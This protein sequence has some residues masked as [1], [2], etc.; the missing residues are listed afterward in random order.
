MC[1]SVEGLVNGLGTRRKSANTRRP[2]PKKPPPINPHTGK[3]DGRCREWRP[4]DPLVIHFIQE[5]QGLKIGVRTVREYSRDIEL[6]GA[7][8]LGRPPFDEEGNPYRGPFGNTFER[9]TVSSVRQFL[10]HLHTLDY[11]AAAT[12]RKMAVLRRF[13]DFVKRNGL[14]EDNPAREIQIIRLPKRQPKAIPVKDVM[15]L[16]GT[17]IPDQPE[18]RWRR[19][20]AMLE[21]LYASGMR[22][23]E[24]VGINVS[25]VEF[26]DRRIRVIGKGNNER[27]VF[28]NKA[29]AEALKAYLRVRPRCK[30]GALFV[31]RQGRRLSYQQVGR[32]F[33]TYVTLSG[34]EGKI[35]PHT[36]RHSIA[37]HLHK[38]GVDLMTIKEFL[39]HASIQTTQIYSQMEAEHV[40]R[41]LEK[42]HP[43][44]RQGDVTSTLRKRLATDE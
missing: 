31:S 34:L 13:F 28:F 8:L 16:I 3:P 18:I 15:K 10:M 12:R 22:R 20:I 26:T 23:A 9:A 30:D 19:D 43:R 14:R 4:A 40:R 7:F 24:L 29:T 11:E 32:I 17:R 35:T 41:S 5:L 36:M 6:F 25:D 1:Y 42:H 38:S 21:L 33:E 27:L 44:D 39:G 37:T 2:A